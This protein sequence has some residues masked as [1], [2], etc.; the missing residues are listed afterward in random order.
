MFGFCISYVRKFYMLTF[1]G[2]KSLRFGVLIPYFCGVFFVTFGGC[3]CHGW[4]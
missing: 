4:G 2:C 3:I 1:G